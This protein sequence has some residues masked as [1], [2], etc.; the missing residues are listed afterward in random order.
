MFKE[1]LPIN[2]HNET[3]KGGFTLVEML[4]VISIIGVLASLLLP[5]VNKARAAARGTQCQSNLRQFGVGMTARTTTAPDSTF[6]SGDFNFVRDGVPTEYGWV[7]DLISRGV[8]VGEMRCVSNPARTSI[9]VH[10]LLTVELAD[11]NL[12][13]YA[14]CAPCA[15]CIG[16]RQLGSKPYENQMGERVVN[17]ARKFDENSLTSAADRASIVERD[18]IQKGYNTNYAG[19]WFL[20]RTEFKLDDNG[21]PTPKDTCASALTSGSATP[22][23]QDVVLDVRGRYMTRGPLTTNRADTA[24]APAN[25]I[26]LL[27]DAAAIGF[28]QA[29]LSE[30][31]PA[32]SLY[33]VSMVGRP[34]ALKGS[35][36]WQV[37]DVPQ[38]A[39][40]TPREGKLGWLRTWNYDTRQDY[41]GMAP[42]HLGAV[43]VLMADGG[44][45]TLVDSNHD[46]FINNGFRASSDFWTSDEVEATPAVLASYHSLTS[47][48]EQD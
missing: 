38:F 11:I 12:S 18:V 13:R 27:C 30:V 21:N 17:V 9:A 29:D 10:Q 5:A 45:R 28:L 2:F 31:I 37:L 7:A 43:N 22:P 41:R 40:G 3:P 36:D 4:V 25:T 46:G 26:P 48:G 24:S 16:D 47:K 44:V 14:G 8:P 39:P 1:S 35:P 42:V 34:S 6:C 19:T 33:A 20:F 23:L 32:Q 15:D